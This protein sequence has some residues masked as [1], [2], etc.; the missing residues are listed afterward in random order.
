MCKAA[1]RVTSAFALT[2]PV[3]LPRNAQPEPQEPPVS[4][5]IQRSAWC[6]L[7]VLTK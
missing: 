3:C 5:E 2:C 1:I 7:A 4:C 6:V